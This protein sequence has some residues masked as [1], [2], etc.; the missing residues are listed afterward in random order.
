RGASAVQFNL[1]ARDLRSTNVILVSADAEGYGLGTSAAKSMSG[2]GRYVA[3]DAWVAWWPRLT[4]SYVFDFVTR[5]NAL[6]CSN[7]SD[8]SLSADGRVI[9]YAGLRTNTAI[10]DIY[11]RDR[12]AGTV[13]RI[14]DSIPNDSSSRP[15][16]SADGRYVVFTSK[17]SNW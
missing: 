5:A 8:P 11:V 12:A 14:G 7:C 3:Y 10:N 16:L 15:L 4:N 2:D 17:A 6:I 13:A 1:F 9:A